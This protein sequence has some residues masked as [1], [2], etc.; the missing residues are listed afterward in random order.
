MC[1]TNKLFEFFYKDNKLKSGYRSRCKECVDK[2]Q[3][4]YNKKKYLDCTNIICKNCK[5][6]KSIDNFYL[7]SKKTN[8]PLKWIICKECLISRKKDYDKNNPDKVCKKK[9]EYYINNKEKI[10]LNAREKYK[11][12]INYKIKCILRS[13]FRLALK[14]NIKTSSS[15]KLL[16]CSLDFF[17][18][19]ISY[20]FE[21]WMLWDNHGL[22][23]LDHVKPCSS[24]N[25][26]SIEEQKECFN[27]KN[28]QPL[29]KN[30]NNSKND[31]IDIEL[32]NTHKIIANNYE[33]NNLNLP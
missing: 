31:K 9:K 1:K 2:K 8:K 27:W 29:K 18:E 19:W 7:Q 10:N 33:K 22:W 26:L 11:N 3:D 4:D 32:I 20:Q 21:D 13:R 30:L 12:D 25:L 6:E 24:Y 5:I 28:Y 16:G 15:V 14:N 23:E 17:K